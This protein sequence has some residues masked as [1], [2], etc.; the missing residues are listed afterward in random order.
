LAHQLVEEGEDQRGIAVLGGDGD[1][2][3][4]ALAH[5]HEG[6][7]LE[8]DDGHANVLLLHALLEAVD[9]LLSHVIAVE[10]LDEHLALVVDEEDAGNHG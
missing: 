6:G 9:G 2:V 1:D 5:V 10:A 4:V 7:V 8:E 3:N